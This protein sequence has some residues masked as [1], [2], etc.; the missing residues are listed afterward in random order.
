MSILRV[1][2]ISFNYPNQNFFKGVQNI[3]FELGQGE[4]LAIVGKSGSGKTTLIKCIYGLE[5]LNSGEVFLGEEKVTGPAYNLIPGHEEM[6]LVS[7][8]FYVLDNHT[9]EENFFDKM[10]GFTDEAKQKRSNQLLKLLELE[11]LKSI[12]TRFLSSGQK[13]RVAIGRAF[14]IIPKLL[15]MDEPFSNLDKLLSEKLFAFISH[16]V[17]KNRT[18]VILITHVPEEALKYADTLAIMENGKIIQ[19]GKKWDVYYK[20]KNTRLAGLMGDYSIIK[21]EDLEKKVQKNFPN[22]IFL[23]PDKLKLCASKD[24][25]DVELLVTDC[26]FNGKCFELLSQTKSEKN[27]LVYS[28]KNLKTDRNYF[29]K[30]ISK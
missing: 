6:K 9:V 19:Y 13:Q 2:N 28:E 22:K 18:S 4:T 23:R 27:C 10:I 15:L 3:S 14:A 29:F 17:K 16:E 20:P 1:K 26:T 12:K 8:D 24:A 7:Q 25:A 11:K 5:N 21:R 30:I